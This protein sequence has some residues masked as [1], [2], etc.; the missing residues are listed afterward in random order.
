MIM[1][2]L[3]IPRGEPRQHDQ[4]RPRFGL[5]EA[6]GTVLSLAFGLLLIAVGVIILTR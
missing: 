1:L 5:G 3:A 2:L 6:A 4:E